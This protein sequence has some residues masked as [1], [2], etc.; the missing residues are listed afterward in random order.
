VT[1]PAL[2]GGPPAF[3]D[4]LPFVRPPVPPLARVVER[5]APSY[6]RGILTN[7]PLAREL[8]ERAA[9]RLGVPHVLAVAS[10]TAGLMLAF[11]A[12]APS[13][14]VV[15]PSF[16]FS[17]SA[18]AVAWNGLAPRFADC[19]EDTFQVDLADAGPLLDGASALMVTHVFGAP[20]RP[21]DVERLAG[22]AGVP[23]V[24]DA[25]HGLGALHCGRPVG[26]FGDVEVFSLTPTKLVV[27]GEGGLVATRRDDVAEAIRIGRNYGD[28]GN[29]DTQFV[30]LNAR[31]SELHAALALES[32]AELDEH[33]ATRDELA[34]RYV[35]ALTAIPGIRVQRVEPGDRSTWK[36]FTIAV[37]TE[38]FGVTRDALVAA[39]RADGIDTRNYF[40]PPVHRQR[41]HAAAADRPLPITER[42]ATEVVSLPLYRSLSAA[43]VDRVVA[44][45]GAVHERA[46]A[47]ATAVT[48]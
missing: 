31:L 13:G 36:D 37:D 40:D 25:A 5:L 38:A 2:L 18:H 46:S 14:R 20:C 22:A 21:D 17:A 34:D 33:L 48:V 30:G 11:R 7:G 23:V 29:Y 6:D 42:V 35:R 1:T 47:V 28:P 39:L 26:G 41:S 24:F 9:E 12:L 8:E 10:C 45:I 44:V 32:L 4:G 19:E 27:A 3:P 16:T 43:D 15:M